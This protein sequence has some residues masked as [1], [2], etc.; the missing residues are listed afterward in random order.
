M[1]NI[2]KLTLLFIFSVVCSLQKAN[3]LSIK[4]KPRMIITA[5]PELDDNNSLIRFLLYSTDFKVEGLIYTSSQ[6]HWKGDGKGTKFMVPGRE[7]TKYGLNLCP[8]SSYRWKQDER[9][10]HEAVEAYEKVYSNLKIHNAAYPSPSYLKSKI[11]YGNIEFEG[12]ISKETEGSKLIENVLLDHIEGPVYVTAWGG[13]STIARALKSIEEKYKNKPNWKAIKEKVSKKL[14]LLPS[15]EQ[16][17]TYVD[18]IK[19]NWPDIDIR[20]YKSGPN[21]GYG[22]QL[23]ANTVNAPLLTSQWM[24]NNISSKGPLGS[25]YRVWGD[26]KQMVK[27]DPFDYF[28]LDGYTNEELKKMGYIVWMPK[29]EKG[30]WLGE[31]DTGTFMNILQNGLNAE[32]KETPGGW[33]GKPFTPDPKTDIDPFSNDTTKVKALVITEDYLKQQAALKANE[34]AYPNFFPAAQNDFAARM[35]WSVTN[36]YA[37]SNHAPIITLKTKSTIQ[38][39]S[40]DHIKL[41]TLVKEPD[42]DAYTIHWWQFKKDKLTPLLNITNENSLTPEIEIPTNTKHKEPLYIV[43]EVKDNNKLSLTS[44]KIIKILI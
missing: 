11:K 34:I 31:G 18:Y 8:C 15:G 14:V 3:A 43:L 20:K 24:Q 10:I 38:A 17:N 7:Y 33:G 29:Q 39:K 44:Y 42:G 19:P 23:V 22:A 25:I 6:F 36:N 5:D 41:S 12:D 2:A 37:G 40:G 1:K 35:Q 26:G 32:D 4:P 9:F 28:G 21:Y 16:D 30:A 13:E 27:N